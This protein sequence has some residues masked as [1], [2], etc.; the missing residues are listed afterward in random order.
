MFVFAGFVLLSLVS[1]PLLFWNG[2]SRVLMIDESFGPVAYLCWGF[3]S[4][5]SLDLV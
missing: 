4:L 5:M 3:G 1:V 2:W